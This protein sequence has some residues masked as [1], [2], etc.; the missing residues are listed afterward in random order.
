M[1]D[2]PGIRRTDSETSRWW[3]RV[4]EDRRDVWR[5][6]S[7]AIVIALTG[8]VIAWFFMAPAPPDHVTIA[9]GHRDG[10][11]YKYCAQYAEQ[12]AQ[13]GVTLHVRETK[14]SVENYELLRRDDGV[15]I[16]IVQGGTSPDATAIRELEGIASVYLEPLWIF[17]HGN[18]ELTDIRELRNRRIAIG[19]AGS[20]TRRMSEQ[21]LKANGL[22]VNDRSFKPDSRTGFEAAAAL[23]KGELDVA[24]FVTT[25]DAGYVRELMRSPDVHLLNL[26][27]QQAYAQL[28]PWLQPITLAQGV[29]DLHDDLPTHDVA[30]IAPSASLVASPDL[31]DAFIPLFLEAAEKVHG[32][33][34]MFVTPGAFPSARL[35]EPTLNASASDYLQHGPSLFHRYLPFWVAS[36]ISRTKILLVPLLTLLIPLVR[37]TPPIYRWRIRSRIYRWYEV[38]RRIDQE[39]SEERS[40]RA[41]LVHQAELSR[42]EM[43]LQEI[44]VPLSYMEEFYNLRLHLDLV[45]R[46]VN[47]QRPARAA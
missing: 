23:Q 13:R 34:D 37:V 40:G 9:A 8:F 28:Y 12:L 4:A 22:S 10:A 20:G 32:G 21:I 38:L 33:G 19:P 16:A 3:Q 27:R 43:E 11:Y 31:H 26:R 30:M 29:V 5:T 6:F 2:T 25:A 46:R 35:V 36:L 15:D 41:I 45:S 14:G 42:I 39:L 24:F 18:Q 47:E 1:T 44:K 17:C 7:P